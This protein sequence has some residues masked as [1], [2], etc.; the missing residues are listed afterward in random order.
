MYWSMARKLENYIHRVIQRL[1]DGR[2]AERRRP[3]KAIVGVGGFGYTGRAGARHIAG[4]PL[5]RAGAGVA[6]IYGA[7]LATVPDRWGDG[8]D[9]G[10]RR[11]T[12]AAVF[13]LRARTKPGGAAGLADARWGCAS[14]SGRLLFL[15]LRLVLVTTL[16]WTPHRLRHAI[17]L[18]AFSTPVE[19]VGHFHHRSGLCH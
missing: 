7:V 17:V 4:A 19:L 10:R 11:P 1:H 2:R 16:C 6:L 14:Y 15:T 12:T 3:L 13:D 5:G 18:Q 9:S 8:L